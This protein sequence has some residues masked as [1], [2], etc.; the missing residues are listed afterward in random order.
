MNVPNPNRDTPSIESLA[1][2]F[3]EQL[4]G[5]DAPTIDGYVQAYPTLA[6][7]ICDLFPTILNMETLRRHKSSGRPIPGH[8]AQRMPEKLG[9][10]RIRDGALSAGQ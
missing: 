8:H 6:D 2:R 9:D 4:H 10:Y 3:I 5:G 7:E 1:E